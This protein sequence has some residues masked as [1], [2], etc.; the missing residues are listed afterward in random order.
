MGYPMALGLRKIVIKSYTQISLKELIELIFKNNEYLEEIYILGYESYDY[1]MIENFPSR[2][3]IFQ[4]QDTQRFRSDL[5]F[6]QIENFSPLL[7]P[8]SQLQ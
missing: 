5:R 4:V 1:L 3:K 7:L 6:L 8:V 2:L